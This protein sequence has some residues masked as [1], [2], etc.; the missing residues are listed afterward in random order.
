[1]SHYQKT[2]LMI[3]ISGV[4]LSYAIYALKKYKSN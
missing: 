3:T 4:L 2:T 1:M